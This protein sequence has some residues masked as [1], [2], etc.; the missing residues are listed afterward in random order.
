VNLSRTAKTVVVGLLM[1]AVVL[2]VASASGQAAESGLTKLGRAPSLPAGSSAAGALPGT[3]AVNALVTLQPR[4]PAALAAYADAVSTPGSDVYHQ[5][6]TVAQ[7]AERFGPTSAQI[8]AVRASLAAQGLA[9]GQP[10]ADGLSVPVT[11]SAGS[12]ARAFSTSFERYRLA[13]GATGFANTS[14]PSVPTG[15]AGLVQG[16]V[17]LSSLAVERP[18]GLRSSRSPAT[19]L[20]AGGAAQAADVTPPDETAPCAPA[21]KVSAED[22][23]YTADEI[24]SA[25]GLSSLHSAGDD[26]SGTTVALFELEPYSATDLSAYRTCYGT[27]TSVTNESVDG[28]AGTGSGSGEAALDIEDVIGLAPA[29]AIRVYEGPNNAAGVYET[30]AKIIS[31]DTA[32]VVSTSW[33]TCESVEGVSAAE[34][35]NTLFQEAATQGQTVFAAAGDSGA[36]DCGGSSRTQAVDDPASQPYVTGIGGTSLPSSAGGGETVWNDGSPYGAGGGGV[37]TLWPRPSYQASAA[38]SQTSTTCGPGGDTCREVPDASADADE[39]TGYVIYYKGTWQTTGGT[40]GAAPTWA[41]LAALADAS[42]ACDKAHVGFVNPI[43][44]QAA[45]SSYSSYFN[46]VTSGNNA[47][48]GVSGFYAGTG[49]DMAS[50]LG[51]PKG[52]AVASAMCGKGISSSSSATSSSA[53]TIPAPRST[54][55]V[56]LGRPAAQTGRL[57]LSEHLHLQAGDSS[58]LSLSYAAKGLPAGLALDGRSGLISGKP[59]RVGRSSVSVTAMDSRG[60]SATVTFEWTVEGKPRVKTS[61]RRADGDR[62]KLTVAVSAGR[63]EPDIRKIVVSAARGTIRFSGRALR[64]DH[65]GLARTGAGHR[66]KAA[67][68]VSRGSLVVTLP[69]ASA[70]EAVLR[71]SAP[72][73]SLAAWLTVD[74]APRRG[75]SV[76]LTLTITDAAGISTV[77]RVRVADL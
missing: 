7:F 77:L 71:L 8:A 23:S 2:I 32:Q 44:Y 17:G 40:S 68:R 3:T 30:Y 26:G 6:L 47:Y 50:G 54:S 33:G 39:D 16:V 62:P 4:D 34:A 37:S 25:Y 76:R 36:Q 9:P 53:T 73:I 12:L 31:D 18:L 13:G 14:A 5:Y 11:A 60:N 66:L 45:A 63:L 38:K 52:A 49:Y 48:D 20:N 19:P 28:G 61:L 70:R 21:H 59:T 64:S 24:A 35:E 58:G 15:V 51:T 43:L 22:G 41:S 57:A 46:D 55:V 29:A 74:S 67:V 27:T 10:A 42:P 65:G 1:T 56:T 75:A 69:R 72:Q